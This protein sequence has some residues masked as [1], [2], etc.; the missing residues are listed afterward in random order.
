MATTAPTRRARLWRR[1]L[2]RAAVCVLL[3]AVTTVG[4]AWGCELAHTVPWPRWMP[5][6]RVDQD[7]ETASWPYAV[8][9]HWGTF[10]V[11]YKWPASFGRTETQFVSQTVYGS[12]RVVSTGWPLPA[13]DAFETTGSGRV[14]EQR[15]LATPMWMQR[16]FPGAWRLGVVPLWPG[17]LLDTL[18]YAV[19]WWIVLITPRATMRWRRKRR[20][21]C[22]A[23]GYDL[24][25]LGGGTVLRTVMDGD[26]SD[27][28]DTARRA[29]P[30]GWVVCPECGT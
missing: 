20:G 17:F 24:R 5:R 16:R 15:G 22:V 7:V 18:I 30:P 28:E 2:T 11:M 13:L 12:Q 9:E 26:A 27:E 29:V 23:C 4:A 21:R 25:G 1:R 8:A 19:P 6:I 3:G 14:F 10:A